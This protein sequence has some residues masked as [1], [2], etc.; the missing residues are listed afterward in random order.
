MTITDKTKMAQLLQDAYD[1]IDRNL[2]AE[3]D[4]YYS[5]VIF[6]PDGPGQTPREKYEMY[7]GFDDAKLLKDLF[8]AILELEAESDV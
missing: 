5:Y 7:L 8:A 6:T 4:R 3:V 1:T 2:E